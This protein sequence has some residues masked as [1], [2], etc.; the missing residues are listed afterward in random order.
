MNPLIALALLL[1]GGPGV[2]VGLLGGGELGLRSGCRLP[3]PV[4]CRK[5][6]QLPVLLCQ[7]RFGTGQL[8][9]GSPQGFP[10]LFQLAPALGQGLRQCLHLLQ[11]GR[12]PVQGTAA[13]LCRQHGPLQLGITGQLFPCHRQTVGEGFLPLRS[14]LGL[15]L[16]LLRRFLLRLGKGQRLPLC[17]K[18]PLSLGTLSGRSQLLLHPAGLLCQLFQLLIQRFGF[19]RVSGD[20]LIQQPRDLSGGQ[21]VR[22]GQQQIA[23]ERAL[24]RTLHRLQI[25]PQSG[26]L[27]LAAVFQRAFLSG[28]TLLQLPEP[29]GAEQLPEDLLALLGGSQQHPQ[30]VPL[31]DHG[32]LGELLLGQPDDLHDLPGDFGGFGQRLGQAGAGE[33]GLGSLPGDAAA[34]QCRTLIG[35]GALHPVGLVAI[36]KF[37]LHIGAG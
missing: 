3:E 5:V 20:E 2:Q 24:R 29:L 34:P 35:R 37:Q 28:E 11:P 31:G 33:F 7:C 27:G 9:P 32:D 30:E 1:I 25:L 23:I 36:G 18:L 26:Q 21:L 14:R 10:L 19:R 4:G 12:R 13:F 22:P 16:G 15:L 17:R 6:L 8:L